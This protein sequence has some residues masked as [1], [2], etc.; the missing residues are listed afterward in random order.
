[1]TNL[2]NIKAN[3]KLIKELISQGYRIAWNQ[4]TNETEIFVKVSYSDIK[5]DCNGFVV[6]DIWQK[7]GHVNRKLAQAII[8]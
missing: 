2:E 8:L 3:N 1:M 6:G 7:V 4:E 5:R